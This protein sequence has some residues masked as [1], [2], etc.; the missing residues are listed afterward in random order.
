M[1]A[2]FRARRRL[3]HDVIDRTREWA[4][5]QDDVR[6][7]VVVVSYAYDAPRM[8]SDVDIVVVTTTPSAYLTGLDFTATI[9][10]R[11]RAVRTQ[12]WGAL[13]ERRIRLPGGLLVE[14]GFV[15]PDWCALPLDPGTAHV[16]AHGCWVLV[17]DGCIRVALESL[18]GR[19]E[20]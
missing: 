15:D 8:G 11:A 19:K 2:R 12:T 4:E 1:S 14:F 17:D 16:L 7:C 13:T 3:A 18:Y 6:S 10:P 9:A 20:P 5:G